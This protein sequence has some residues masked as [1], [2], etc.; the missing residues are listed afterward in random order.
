MMAAMTFIAREEEQVSG[1]IMQRTRLKRS[2][3]VEE[4]ERELVV[5]Q[6]LLKFQYHLL[7]SMGT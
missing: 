6:K 5:L 2:F 4:R 3:T 1:F 7:A